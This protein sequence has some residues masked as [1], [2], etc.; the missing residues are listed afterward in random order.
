MAKPILV[1]GRNLF[2]PQAAA[3]AGFDYTGVGRG[4][5]PRNAA[6]PARTEGVAARTVPVS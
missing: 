2:D 6:Q 1:D 4:P 5:V 3:A